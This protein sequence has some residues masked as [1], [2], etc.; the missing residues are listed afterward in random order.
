MVIEVEGM[1]L[2]A[3]EFVLEEYDK[4]K[5]FWCKVGSSLVE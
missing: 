3:L 1:L 5:V 2:V 4:L